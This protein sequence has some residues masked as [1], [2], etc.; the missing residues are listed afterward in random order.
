MTPPV[1]AK[2]IPEA[3]TMQSACYL[4]HLMANSPTL[5]ACPIPEPH[6]L[7]GSGEIIDLSETGKEYNLTEFCW[8]RDNVEKVLSIVPGIQP[9]KDEGN[10]SFGANLCPRP[11]YTIPCW[12]SYLDSLSLEKR[13]AWHPTHG[14]YLTNI[15]G[16]L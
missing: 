9:Q 1:G 4:P 16:W 10:L 8:I 15:C 5:L 7:C 13:L 12:A 11:G 2:K 14:S 6:E 3:A